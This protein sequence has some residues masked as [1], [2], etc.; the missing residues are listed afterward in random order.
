MANLKIVRGDNEKEQIKSIDGLVYSLDK[1]ISGK[2]PDDKLAQ[3]V[4]SLKQTVAVLL[5]FL[6]LAIEPGPKKIIKRVR[7]IENETNPDNTL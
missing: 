4:T 6:G 7:L 1:K 3:E 5:D 2:S